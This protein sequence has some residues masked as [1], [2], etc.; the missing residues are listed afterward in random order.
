MK[1]KSGE[2]RPESAG[3]VVCVLNIVGTVRILTI[4]AY[5]AIGDDVL[6]NGQRFGFENVV[7]WVYD[8]DLMDEAMD[9]SHDR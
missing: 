9:K 4:G 2:E 7:R 8:C 3:P 5:D 6:I 1:W